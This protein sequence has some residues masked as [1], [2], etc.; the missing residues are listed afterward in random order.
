MSVAIEYVVCL[1]ATKLPNQN[2]HK[3]RTGK[4]R[5]V[6]PLLHNYFAT[7]SARNV[8]VLIILHDEKR[9]GWGGER[10]GSGIGGETG[11]VIG[12]RQKIQ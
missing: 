5:V 12:T 1:I 7:I 6:F 3:N 4:C 10:E 11:T 8:I 9:M 2:I